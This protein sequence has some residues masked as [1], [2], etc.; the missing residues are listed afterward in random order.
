[1]GVNKPRSIV[2]CRILELHRASGFEYVGCVIEDEGTR[3]IGA[4]QLLDEEERLWW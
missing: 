1:M 4:T 2:T 3:Q